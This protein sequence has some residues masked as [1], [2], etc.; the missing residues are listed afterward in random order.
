[1]R[2]DVR[3]WTTTVLG[4][5]A[6]ACNQQR[7]TRS[8]TP[9]IPTNK[10][11][12][13]AQA[14]PKV[15][16]AQAEP[17][18]VDT[19]AEPKVVDTK[20]KATTS[21]T[22]D[23]GQIQGSVEE[24]AQ[25]TPPSTLEQTPTSPTRGLAEICEALCRR[26]TEKC[27]KQVAGFYQSSCN[28]YLKTPGACEEQ[29]RLALECQF[30]AQDEVLCAHAADFNCSQVNRELKLCQRGTAPVEQTTAEDDRTLPPG[31][32]QVQDLELGFT[33]AMP[34]GATLD[35]EGKRRTWKAEE[36]GISYYV[37]ALGAPPSKLDNQALVRTVVS[38]VG[39]SCQLG[40]KLNGQLDLKGTT[41]VQYHSAC[42][43]KTEWHGMLHVWNGKV[44]STGYHAQAGATGV[45]EPYFYSFLIEQ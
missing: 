44:V 32:Q 5:A 42:P 26:A 21:E 36:N 19:Q 41:V 18:V 20:E 1:M 4:I 17:K 31:W 12:V 14:E 11:L 16:D 43:D 6:V 25:P 45:R 9:D 8:P 29:L 15:V 38:Y 30:K 13:D 24:T 33:V 7:E 35:T 34:P 40:L 22:S 27:N 23:A 2:K 39:G 28:H 37:A 3:F 10:T